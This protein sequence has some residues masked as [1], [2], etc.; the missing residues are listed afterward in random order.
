MTA[1][2]RAREDYTCAQCGRTIKKGEIYERYQDHKVYEKICKECSLS[3]KKDDWGRT[4]LSNYYARV[5]AGNPPVQS[6]TEETT[7]K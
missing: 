5:E 1:I 4:V 7:E 2:G 3:R 6:P